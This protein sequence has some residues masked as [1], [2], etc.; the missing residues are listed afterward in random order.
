MITFKTERIGGCLMLT[1]W[2][3]GG[4]VKRWMIFQHLSQ[5]LENAGWNI[6][7]RGMSPDGQMGIRALRF[8]D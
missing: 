2:V 3:S 1:V 7:E 8:V 6:R 4:M 5:H